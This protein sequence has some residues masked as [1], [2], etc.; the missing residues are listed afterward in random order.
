MLAEKQRLS[1]EIIFFL[2]IFFLFLFSTISK[3][4]LV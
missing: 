1:N 3:T 4:Q 2:I